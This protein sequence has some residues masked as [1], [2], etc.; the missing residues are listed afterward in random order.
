MD[1]PTDAMAVMHIIGNN[2]E[3]MI[4]WN[5]ST[6]G[7]V[8]IPKQLG[9]EVKW[10]LDV[11]TVRYN[12]P[13]MNES[14]WVAQPAWQGLRVSGYDDFRPHLLFHQIDYEGS[15]FILQNHT[16]SQRHNGITGQGPV[17]RVEYH[18]AE[19][20]IEGMPFEAQVKQHHNE[21]TGFIDVQQP[22]RFCSPQQPVEATNHWGLS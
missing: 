18:S 16:V 13:Q 1:I 15:T 5:V 2:E 17:T 6:P 19:A 8:V 3:A 20:Q 7:Y 10:W 22:S 4:A 9:P 11:V 21:F 14:P 12:G